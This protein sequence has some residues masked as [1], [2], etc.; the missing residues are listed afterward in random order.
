SPVDASARILAHVAAAW[1][2]AGVPPL[3]GEDVFLTVPASFDA[4][5]RELTVEAARR[6]GL[7]RVTLLEEP[8]AAFYSYLAHAGDAWRTQLSVGDVVLVCDIGGGTTDF[9][10]IAVGEKDGDLV[11]DRVAVGD[12][13]LLG[14]D[15]MDL[16]LSYALAQ[17]IG[18][19]LDAWQQRSLVHAARAA[20]E[21]ILAGAADRL[22]VAILGRGSRLIGG[23]LKTELSRDEVER[24]LID[25]FF[26]MTGAGDRPQ[27]GRKTG[28]L[29][30]GLPYAS[31]AAVT[32]HLAEFVARHGRRP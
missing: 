19:K 13:I 10:L 24:L 22:P 1:A 16:A 2:H 11:L 3:A 8:Q 30:L 25:G 20:K 26:P 15:N 21:Q 29:E 18:Q 17:K 23:T 7:L 14:G 5:G 6:A 12:H 4:V 9:T 32:R 27:R 28:I 31:D